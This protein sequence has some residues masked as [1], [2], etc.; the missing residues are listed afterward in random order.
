MGKTS[1]RLLEEHAVVLTEVD[2]SPLVN[3]FVVRYD[4]RDETDGAAGGCLTAIFAFDSF[5]A[6]LNSI[7]CQSAYSEEFCYAIQIGLDTL[8]KV[9]IVACVVFGGA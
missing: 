3:I 2:T 8:G 6:G 1:E 5:A 9:I 4:V 7:I